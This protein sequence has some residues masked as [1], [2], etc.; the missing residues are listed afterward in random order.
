MNYKWII[1]CYLCTALVL[2]LLRMNNFSLNRHANEIK[3]DNSPHVPLSADANELEDGNVTVVSLIDNG[4]KIKSGL[5]KLCNNTKRCSAF[6]EGRNFSFVHITKCAGASWVR[7]FKF[8]VGEKYFNPKGNMEGAEYTVSKAFQNYPNDIQLISIK[9]P[10]HHV[11]SLFSQCKYGWFGQK[12]T[13]NTQFPRSGDSP[14]SD[15]TDFSKWLDYF[16]EQQEKGPPE[17]AKEFNCYHP[18][19]FQT[20]FMTAGIHGRPQSLLKI[21]GQTDMYNP[22]F[23][24]A[25]INYW[26]E[27]WVG[28]TEFYHESKCMFCYRVILDKKKKQTKRSQDAIREAQSYIDTFCHCPLKSVGDEHAVHHKLGHRSQM[29]NL[30]PKILDKVKILTQVD[31]EM[32]VVALFQ[33]LKEIVWLES[34]LGLDRDVLCSASLQK[35]EPELNYLGYN[36]SRIFYEIKDTGKY[37]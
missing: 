35:I 12:L 8:L 6:T 17:G 26:R 2:Y 27:D 14:E 9:S 23:H 30:S 1:G 3:D 25:N 18:S 37:L 19:N 7:D 10:R 31:T 24:T 4:N 32:Y 34:S 29:R 22:P 20:R 28:L 5:S 33:F 21:P 16:V 11:W 13:L 36:I 15:V